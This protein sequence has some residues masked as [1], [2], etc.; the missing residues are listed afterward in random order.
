MKDANW[1]RK[2]ARRCWTEEVVEEGGGCLD[3]ENWSVERGMEN[4]CDEE[5]SSCEL[6]STIDEASGFVCIIV[7]SSGSLSFE[8][9]SVATSARAS[10]ASSILL[11]TSSAFLSMLLLLST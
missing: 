5:E 11:F 3:C 8:S 6:L 7:S 4:V 10:S 1:V 2:D 9:G